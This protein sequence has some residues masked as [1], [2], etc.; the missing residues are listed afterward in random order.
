MHTAL[1]PDRDR[2][3]SSVAVGGTCLALLCVP[4]TTLAEGLVAR[5]E[6]LVQAGRRAMDRHEYQ[7]AAEAFDAAG[8]LVPFW[9]TCRNAAVAWRHCGRPYA[10]QRAWSCVADHPD[11][12]TE[13]RMR[14]QLLLAE[15]KGRR[16]EA[17]R[18]DRSSEDGSVVTASSDAVP[19]SDAASTL[20]AVP[21]EVRP[22]DRGI[23]ST[24]WVEV[25]RR[26]DVAFAVNRDEDRQ[27]RLA[28]V[29]EGGQ[30]RTGKACRELLQ[31]HVPE[32]VLRGDARLVGHPL[33]EHCRVAGGRLFQAPEV[34]Q[35]GAGRQRVRGGIEVQIPLRTPPQDRSRPPAPGGADR[36]GRG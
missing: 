18:L 2:L 23:G 1:S 6:L 17:E 14:A 13:Q 20:V 26:Q 24:M 21:A 5:S 15:L 10:E 27:H 16:S 25:P 31:T 12:P 7:R 11:T 3:R 29:V 33:D 32:R 4:C 19:A 22:G 36:D 28:P 30:P 9:T 8:A 34:Q 35:P